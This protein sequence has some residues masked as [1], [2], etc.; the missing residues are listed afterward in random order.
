MTISFFGNSK[1]RGAEGIRARLEAEIKN[2]LRENEHITFYCGGY[3]DFDLLCGRVLHDLKREGFLFDHFYITPY[4]CDD[5][6]LKDED[7]LKRY[8]AVIYPPLESTPPRF[9]ILAR[10]QWMI[11]QS[12]LIFCCVLYS[13]GG[14]GKARAYAEKVGKRIIDLV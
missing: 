7:F 8:D 4:L 3:G 2:L 11:E 6:R 12:D 5:R 1:L 10:N 14:A 13:D 9:A